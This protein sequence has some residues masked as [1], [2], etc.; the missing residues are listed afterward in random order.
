MVTYAGDTMAVIDGATGRVTRTVPLA[1]HPS[2]IAADSRTN[3]VYIANQGA[4]S[5]LVLDGETG[6]TLATV[7]AGSIPYAMALDTTAGQV[8]VANFASDSATVIHG[9]AH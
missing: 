9:A 8:Y 4:S 5:V 3:R 6:A 2:A 1:T 7:N